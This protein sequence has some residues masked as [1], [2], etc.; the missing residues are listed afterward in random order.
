MRNQP[1]QNTLCQ[2]LHEPGEEADTYIKEEKLL[3]H[4]SKG[5]IAT[6]V[7]QKKDDKEESALPASANWAKTLKGLS[8]D[9]L[10]F[11]DH[12][13]ATSPDSGEA[14]GL[15][16][17]KSVF[18]RAPVETGLFS[19]V[20]DENDHLTSDDNLNAESKNKSTLNLFSLGFNLVPVYTGPFNPFE[21]DDKV[22]LW[23]KQ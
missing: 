7:S 12:S 4:S 15:E 13:R 20:P 16:T 19:S 10:I 18:I 9:Q 2:Y 23:K 21:E 3:R 17:R 5:Q 11:G 14:S 8:G 22:C 6:S 1:C